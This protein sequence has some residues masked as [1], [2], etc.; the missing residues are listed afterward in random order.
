MRPQDARCSRPVDAL[1]RLENG[2]D[3]LGGRVVAELRAEAPNSRSLVA[4]RKRAGVVKRQWGRAYRPIRRVGELK[5]LWAQLLEHSPRAIG[6]H[7]GQP[8]RPPVV[9]VDVAQQDARASCRQD[10]LD[11]RLQSRPARE[12]VFA[13]DDQSRLVL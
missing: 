9:V 12:A 8:V 5:V 4:V 10:C 3:L 2:E 11:V 13:F 6:Q 7:G 1:R